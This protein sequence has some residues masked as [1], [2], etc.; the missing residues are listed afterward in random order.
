[1]AKE[2]GVVMPLHGSGW[3]K[4]AVFAAVLLLGFVGWTLLVLHEAGTARANAW[5]AEQFAAMH[6]PLAD[7]LFIVI[8]TLGDPLCIGILLGL[9]GLL[10]LRE[11]RWPTLFWAGALAIGTTLLTI[12]IKSALAVSR[13]SGEW[14]PD[15]YSYPSGH[16]SGAVIMAILLATALS[17]HGSLWMRRTVRLAFA[18]Y[19]VMVGAS[20]LYFAVHW[21]SDIVGAMLLVTGLWQSAL[22]LMR[23][24]EARQ[25]RALLIWPAGMGRT[26]PWG[27]VLLAGVYLLWRLPVNMHNYLGG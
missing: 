11:R 2:S 16:M 20:R 15:S 3:V 17:A 6:S 22:G 1:M 10:L 26:L 9:L 21:F 14:L 25:G 7:H 13:P 8:T 4:N 5:V 12:Q 18:L 27:M 23:W 19:A 24:L